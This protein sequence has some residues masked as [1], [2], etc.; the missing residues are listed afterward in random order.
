MCVYVCYAGVESVSSSRE[1]FLIYFYYF[2]FV[3]RFFFFFH[4]AAMCPGGDRKKVDLCEHPDTGL[5]QTDT[6]ADSSCAHS[7]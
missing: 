3:H 6:Y 1:G 4:D 2:D 5:R 7:P